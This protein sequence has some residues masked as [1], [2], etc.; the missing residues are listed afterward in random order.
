LFLKK[1]QKGFPLLSG[2]KDKGLGRKNFGKSVPDFFIII[3]KT[4]QTA[5]LIRN[6][7]TRSDFCADE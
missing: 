5:A 3:S 2:L 4:E 7:W 1:K 6:T